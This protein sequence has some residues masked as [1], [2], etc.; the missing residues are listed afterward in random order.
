MIKENG[1]VRSLKH[2]FGWHVAE[3]STS[4]PNGHVPDHP[5]DSVLAAALLPPH[6]QNEQAEVDAIISRFEPLL[7]H[8]PKNI[9]VIETLAEAYARKMMF[10]QS[11]SLYRRALEIVGGKNAAI[12][13]AIEETTLK[14]LDLEL[15]STRSEGTRLRH[16][17]RPAAK[18]AIGISMARD[19]GVSLTT[20]WNALI[21]PRD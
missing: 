9:K 16:S 2:M 14:K 1:I 8:C 17:T 18:P 13:H 10:N 6:V 15:K 12:E 5:T 3:G 21:Q 7:V 11:L 19:G 20:L 4:G